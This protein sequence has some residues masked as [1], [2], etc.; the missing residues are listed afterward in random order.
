LQKR[1]TAGARLSRFGLAQHI[2]R[3]AMGLVGGGDAAIHRDQEED[4]LNLL[5]RAAV[6]CKSQPDLPR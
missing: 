6:G 3:N 4:V 5:G 2:D 1:N